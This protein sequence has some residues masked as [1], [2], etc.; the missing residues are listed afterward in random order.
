M[1]AN[2]NRSTE[3]VSNEMLAFQ[4]LLEKTPDDDLLREV[5]ALVT[6]GARLA[7]A[8]TM[9]VDSIED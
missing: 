5:F 3:P 4:V 9:A 2:P 8:R 7:E 6:Y 1:R